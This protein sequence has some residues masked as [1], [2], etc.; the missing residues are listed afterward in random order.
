M[1][2]L[3]QFIPRAKV[4]VWPLFGRRNRKNSRASS[5]WSRQSSSGSAPSPRPSQAFRNWLDVDFDEPRLDVLHGFIG[6]LTGLSNA[7]E[8]YESPHARRWMGSRNGS[9]FH[10]HHAIWS[11]VKRWSEIR[12]SVD[13]QQTPCNMWNLGGLLW[14]SK[15]LKGKCFVRSYQ[16]PTR[17]GTLVMSNSTI[18]RA[19]SR[20]GWGRI[21]WGRQRNAYSG[22]N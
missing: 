17:G 10:G 15:Q 13:S 9:D 22:T 18:T 5:K 7:D 2:Q 3:F 11:W 8:V 21:V 6:P 1:F 12:C 20:L 16:I 4:I 19:L 14:I